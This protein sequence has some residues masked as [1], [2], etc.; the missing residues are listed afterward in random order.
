MPAVPWRLRAL[1]LLAA[2]AVLLQAGS[3]VG[4]LI[5]LLVLALYVGFWL[6]VPRAWSIALAVLTVPAALLAPIGVQQPSEVADLLWVYPAIALCFAAPESFSFAVLIAVTLLA[7]VTSLAVPGEAV[8]KVVAFGL[9]ALLAGL[10]ASTARRLLTANER[11]AQAQQ[12]L[13]AAAV[14]EERVRFSRDLHDLLGHSLTVLVA[15][16]RLARRLPAPEADSELADAEH[17][18]LGALDEVRQAVEGY[19]APTLDSQIAGAR[20]ALAAAGIAFDVS[21]SANPV[22]GGAEGALAISV[23]EAVT[24]VLR[25]SG[26]SHCW[27]TIGRAQGAA[28]VE[29]R[30]DGHGAEPGTASGLAGIRERLARLG[31]TVEWGAGPDGGFRVHVSVPAD[32]EVEAASPA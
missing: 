29:V 5:Y 28:W 14:Q 25:H 22:A 18:A 7:M 12:Q 9:P 16:L 20:A 4:H 27:I 10:A 17:L 31:G 32:S 30:D 1:A 23:R 11:L 19:R 26:A 24:N 6:A 3:S 2:P 21:G 8:H 15:K 13:A